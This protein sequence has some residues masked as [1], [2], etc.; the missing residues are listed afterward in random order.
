VAWRNDF[1]F[2]GFNKRT[3]YGTW[4]NKYVYKLDKLTNNAA[5][6]KHQMFMGHG[7]MID[8]LHDVPKFHKGM[9][10]E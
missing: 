9:N 5:K 3:D 1:V 7:I 4:K 6:D 10:E 2:P 8:G